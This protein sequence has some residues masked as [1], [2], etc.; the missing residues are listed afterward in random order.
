MFHTLCRTQVVG[1]IVSV[2]GDYQGTKRLLKQALGQYDWAV[3]RHYRGN[4]SY[5][6][7]TAAHPLPRLLAYHPDL[8]RC[9]LM[10]CGPRSR[11]VAMKSGLQ[12]LIHVLAGLSPAL[13]HLPRH[14][15]PPS[16]FQLLPR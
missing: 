7:S 16:V 15:A 13:T 5:S 11:H 6:A 9:E 1:H 4:L 10:R 2:Q 14:T 8:I 12:V 3:H